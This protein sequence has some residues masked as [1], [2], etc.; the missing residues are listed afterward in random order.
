M[1]IFFLSITDAISLASEKQE[2][3]LGLQD[4][5]QYSGQS[6]KCFSLDGRDF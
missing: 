2:A 1:I 6:E 4:S 3:S 5:S